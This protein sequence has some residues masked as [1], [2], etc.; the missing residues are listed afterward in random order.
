ML[1]YSKEDSIICHR[2]A[3]RLIDEG[4]SVSINSNEINQFENLSKKLIKKSDCIILCISRN[5]FQ[6][7][8][9]KN[10]AQYSQHIGK[11]IIPIK[12]EYY[13]PIEWLKDLIEKESYFQLYGSENQFNLEYEKILLKIVSCFFSKEKCSIKLPH[14][15]FPTY[16]L[17][18]IGALP[19]PKKGFHGV[20]K[21]KKDLSLDTPLKSFRFSMKFLGFERYVQI[22]EIIMI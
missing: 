1:S 16:I 3:N 5:Y 10:E 13:Q 14:K 6:N 17:K 21:P 12:I 19:N 15:R 22:S 7:E 18:K 2:L 4:F 9:C 11:Y 20:T 8:Y